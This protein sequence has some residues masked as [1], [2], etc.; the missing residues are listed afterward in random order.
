M[1]TEEIVRTNR[2]TL[3]WQ[4]KRFPSEIDRQPAQDIWDLM[5]A[6]EDEN[7]RNKH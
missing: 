4:L 5:A 2:A 1:T 6:I 3:A 7:E